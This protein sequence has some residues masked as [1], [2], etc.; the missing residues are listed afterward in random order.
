[1]NFWF[2]VFVGIFFMNYISPLINIGLDILVS[3]ANVKMSTD[4]VDIQKCAT[5]VQREQNE[6][7]EINT[8]VMGFRYDDPDEEYYYDDDEYE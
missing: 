7:A 1:M 3:R 8:H 2:G 5:L 6:N 4:Q